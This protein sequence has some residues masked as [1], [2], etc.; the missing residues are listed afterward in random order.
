[1]RC[2]VFGAAAAARLGRVDM[3]AEQWLSLCDALRRTSSTL[4]SVGIN[5]QALTSERG[6]WAAP[7]GAERCVRAGL[8]RR[9]GSRP[10]CLE[11]GTW[12]RLQASS[13]QHIVQDRAC[14]LA[15]W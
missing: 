5:M 4:G 14:V 9:A 3:H 7:E 11:R 12:G 1:M 13:C 15:A 2:V 8:D 6:A 10:S